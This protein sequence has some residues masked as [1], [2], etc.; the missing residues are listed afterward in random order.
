MSGACST[1]ILMVGGSKMMNA[2]HTKF[3]LK[4]Q[5]NLLI[6]ILRLLPS[7]C[8]TPRYSCYLHRFKITDRCFSQA[9]VLWNSFSMEL[10]LTYSSSLCPTPFSTLSDRLWTHLD[11]KKAIATNGNAPAKRLKRIVAALSIQ[12]QQHHRSAE[13]SDH[14]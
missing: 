6:L 12:H 10:L 13:T 4:F 1:I 5:F 2:F 7:H 8:P 11:A 3:Y 9:P 14:Q